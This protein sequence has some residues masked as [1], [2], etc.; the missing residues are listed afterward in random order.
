MSFAATP[1]L[2]FPGATNGTNTLSLTTATAAGAKSLPELTDAEAHVTT[3]DWRKIVFALMERLF[4]YYDS[5]A[6]ADKPTKV[7]IT[8]TG[9]LQSNGTINYQY[10]VTINAAATGTEVQAE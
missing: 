8:R 10:I 9:T 7:A 2:L 1:T 5:L 6:L 4:L 3:G